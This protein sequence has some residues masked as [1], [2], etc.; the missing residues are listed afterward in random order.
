MFL[1]ARFVAG[2][3]LKL[4]VDLASAV[5]YLDERDRRAPLARNAAR[6]VTQLGLEWY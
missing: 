2:N 4:L 1:S 5:C 6:R 3:E